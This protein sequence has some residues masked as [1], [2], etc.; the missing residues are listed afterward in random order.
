MYSLSHDSLLAIVFKIKHTQ[1][2]PRF[3]IILERSLLRDGAEGSAAYLKDH[4]LQN[5]RK[6][7]GALTTSLTNQVV[8]QVFTSEFS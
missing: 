1:D 2:L 7:I 6:I 4:L 3:G 8:S 5:G